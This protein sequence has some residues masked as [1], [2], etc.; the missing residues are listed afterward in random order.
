MG[1]FVEIKKTITNANNPVYSST[2]D[3]GGWSERDNLPESDP[4]GDVETKSAIAPYPKKFYQEQAKYHK[5]LRERG[6]DNS[7]KYYGNNA[8]TEDCCD[9]PK[10]YKNVISNS[11]QFYSC[12]NCGSDLGDC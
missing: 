1:G 7:N 10:K 6:M 8:I 12:R 11:L 9:K 5:E 3:N 2:Y 4:V